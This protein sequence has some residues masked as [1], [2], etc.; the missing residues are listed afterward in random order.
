MSFLGD[1]FLLKNEAAK[2]LYHDFAKDCPIYDFHCHLVPSEIA[3]NRQFDSLG[4]I[5]LEADHYKWR[6]MRVA[7]VEERLIT[8]DASF[9][10]KYDAWA[11]TLP[12]CLANPLYHWTHLELQRPFGFKNIVFNPQSAPKIWDQ[13]KELLAQDNFRARGILEA[14]NVSSLG[15][16][17]DPVH[18]LLHHKKIAEDEDFHIKVRPSFRPDRFFKIELASFTQAFMELEQACDKDIKNFHDFISCL[19]ARLEYFASLGTKASDHGMECVRFSPIP[20]L[21]TLNK[22]LDKRLSGRVLEEEE[23]AGFA[24]AVLFHLSKAYKKHNWV[25]QM[26]VGPLRNPSSKGYKA[27]GADSGFDCIGD[28]LF[29]EPL[30]Q[31][32]DLMQSENCL[33]RSILFC[34]NPRDNEALAALCA[35][36][37]DEHNKVQFGSGWWFNDQKNGMERQLEQY[38]QLLLLPLFVGMLTDSR[39]FLSF[40]RHEYFRRILCQ[41]FGSLIEDGEL[42][43][44]YLLVGKAVKDICYENARSFFEDY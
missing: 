27:L 18:D 19:L 16:T 12:K 17:D 25:M 30:A 38:A 9:R 4:Q 1:D 20:S 40:T 32:L 14:M 2:R 33:P 24:T 11:S 28:R 41:K 42:P 44:D 3:E 7:G 23:I 37:C 8:G 21:S 26:H 39:S 34:L 43:E 15:T 6:A 36:F 35:A 5:W 29:I 10:E 13:A 31:L 22:I